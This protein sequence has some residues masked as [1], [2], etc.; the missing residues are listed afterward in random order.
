MESVVVASSKTMKP[1]DSWQWNRS[2]LRH[3][4]KWAS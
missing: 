2:F 1:G 3:S 4:L